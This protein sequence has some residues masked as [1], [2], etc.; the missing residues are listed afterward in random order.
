ME[1]MYAAG[2]GAGD[3]SSMREGEGGG[4]GLVG[5]VNKHAEKILGALDKLEGLRERLPWRRG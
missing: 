3:L 1:Q 5:A 4:G 2:A